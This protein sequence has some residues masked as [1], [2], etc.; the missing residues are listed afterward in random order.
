[1]LLSIGFQITGHN[2]D[3]VE[4]NSF[5]D[6]KI[7]NEYYDH[8]SIMTGLNESR[9]FQ[10]KVMHLN[11]RSLPATFEALTFFLHAM[12][13][14]GLVYDVIMICESVLHDN[15]ARQYSI[16]GYNFVYTNRK[17]TRGGGVCM[18]IQNNIQ[19]RMRNDLSLFHE[20]EFESIFIETLGSKSPF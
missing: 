20:G 2:S 11:M 16:P 7:N 12:S 19:Y 9:T 14:T 13:E 3:S 1:M 17:H 8:D 5:S 15:N 6:L 4:N 10:T 18:Y